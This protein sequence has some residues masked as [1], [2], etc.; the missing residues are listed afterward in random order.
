MAPTFAVVAEGPTDFAVLRQILATFFADPGVVV[1]QLQPAV[2]ATSGASS[3]GGWYEVFR[4]IGSER[5][6]GAFE[7]SVFVVIHI[8]TDVC[9]EPYFG[10]SRREPNG[11]ERSPA[12]MLALTQSRLVQEIGPEVFARFR[13]R[14]IFAI[15]VETIECWLLPLYYTDNR[16][17]KT[18]NCLGSL[19]LMLNAREGFSIDREK[20]G[21][22]KYY[23]KILRHL[24]K[25][26]A[27]EDA[28]KHNP[29]FTA[30]VEA[31]R[32]IR[33]D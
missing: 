13:E 14:I 10:I 26:K 31:L 21:V 1:D 12:E 25:P 32:P 17:S 5:F 33:V 18:T 7:R 3:P 23:L 22:L 24:R 20:S 27:L 11:R 6:I 2:D 28:A 15:A 30:F 9:E 19:N 29:S 8:D 4:Y 16:R